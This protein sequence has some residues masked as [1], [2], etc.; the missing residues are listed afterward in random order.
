MRKRL[1][2]LGRNLAIYGVGDV[3]TSVISFLLLPLYVRYLTPEDYGVLSLLL[4]V[5]VVAKIVFR[6]GIDA[7]FM[8]LYYDC[9]TEDDRRRLTSTLF[10][11]LVVVNGAALAAALAAAPW[12]ARHLFGNEAHTWLLRLVLLNTFVIGF[13][14][15]PFHLL[16]MREQSRRFITVNVTR[17]F[18]TL[19]LRL[20]LVVGAG[21]GV[22][23]IV[24]A[25][26]VVSAFTAVVF[27]RWV[28][29]LI[30]PMFSRAL[31]REALHFGLPRLPHGIA[32][33]VIAVADRY[34]LTRFVGLAD[35]G[36]YSVGASFGLAMKLFLSAFETAWAPFYF[37]TMKA[38]DARRTFAL[39]TLY[40]SAILALL[41]AGL[42]AIAPDLVRL[43]TTPA[44]Y[45]AA[46]VIP[47]IALGVVWQGFYLLTSI[48]LNI[49]KQT[50]Y[51]PMATGIAAVASVGANLW[52]IPRHGVMG[53]AWANTLAYAVLALV[54]MAF[55][56]HVYP[57]RYD[58]RR[59]GTVAAAGLGSWAV[60]ALAVPPIGSP[61]LGVLVRGTTVVAVFP[62]I[63]FVT[64]F[65]SPA[66][67][68]ALRELVARRPAARAPAPDRETVAAA[69]EIVS[70]VT[71]EE[72]AAPDNGDERREP[73][74]G[75]RSG[76]GAAPR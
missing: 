8:R 43:M 6:W 11:F 53:A 52:L 46:S 59:L 66:E 37:A 9:E 39:V 17:S 44:Y 58:W 67:L 72:E 22:F 49:T 16:R 63:L 34:W 25:D 32:H 24:A 64:G 69:G 70:V 75:R 45:G 27:G 57:L 2:S 51:Y 33:Q 42:A 73:T 20:L 74:A 15:L 13:F 47:W 68:R 38:P 30:R 48:G 19:A 65:F 10:W 71:G 18:S 55:S 40:C 28:A 5:E 54:S 4:T 35:I 1:A 14:F 61:I 60:A 62:A 26:L 21:M 56:Q 29:P 50:R 3:A 12:I 7:S 36:L 41:C 23:G 76:A 31:L